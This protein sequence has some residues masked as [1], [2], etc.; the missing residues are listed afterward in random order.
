MPAGKKIAMQKMVHIKNPDI[1][2]LYLLYLE[3]DLKSLSFNK[4]ILQND[5]AIIPW[6]IHVMLLHLRNGQQ[7][8][9]CYNILE[10]GDKILCR[11]TD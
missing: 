3:I 10:S 5:F 9:Y 2:A 7:N 1:F 11:K 4:I 6:Y 8:D